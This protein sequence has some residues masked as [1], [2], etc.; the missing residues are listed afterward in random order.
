MARENLEALSVDDGRTRLVILFFG[1]PHLLE[2]GERGQDRS[3]NPDRVF[4]LRGGND[5]DLHGGRSKSGQFLLHSVS[6]TREHGSSSGEDNI[7]VEIFSDIKIAL[8][9]GV[10]GGLVDSSSFHTQERGLEK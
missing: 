2:G 7:S 9:D 4:S 8:H 6:N 10:V 5:L 1:D 3:S